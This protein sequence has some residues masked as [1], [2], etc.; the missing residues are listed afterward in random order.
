M[1]SKKEAFGTF[2]EWFFHKKNLEKQV[3]TYLEKGMI[4]SAV[5]IYLTE[6]YVNKALKILVEKGDLYKAEDLAREHGLDDIADYCK[7]LAKHEPQ[8]KINS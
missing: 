2:S 7:D 4:N 5:D 6:G 3:E 8:P 1:A